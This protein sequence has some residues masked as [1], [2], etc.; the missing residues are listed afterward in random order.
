[1]GGVVL[2]KRRVLTYISYCGPAT[3]AELAHAL[4]YTTQAGAAATLLRLHR[5][6]HLRR[7]RD[8]SGYRY[9]ISRKGHRWLSLY[10]EDAG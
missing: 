7:A 6:G 4:G 5:H 8:D 1:M 9:S 2:A 10:G 3:S